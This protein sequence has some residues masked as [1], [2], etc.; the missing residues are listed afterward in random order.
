MPITGKHG[1]KR[2][3]AVTEA[4]LRQP[5]WLL[6]VAVAFC[7][8]GVLV[9]V[10]LSAGA[11]TS[12]GS[13]EAGTPVGVGR[14]MTANADAA[15]PGPTGSAAS[16]PI[17]LQPPPST[18]RAEESPR[19]VEPDIDQ[20]PF[21]ALSEEPTG[22][23]GLVLR[24]VVSSLCLDLAGD[25]AAEGA[26]VHQVPCTDSVS[27]RWQPINID[28]E[29]ATVNLANVGSG[30]CLEVV[31]KALFYRQVQQ[32]PCDENDSTQRWRVEEVDEGKVRL[33]VVRGDRCL[34]V[35]GSTTQANVEV[36]V[37][38]CDDDSDQHWGLG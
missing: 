38:R 10:L 20:Q 19:P 4:D 33:I 3:T 1:G 28:A 21:V 7:A 23:E 26:K 11:F 32:S 9:G 18:A 34:T 22:Q 14:L 29:S 8:A 15:T 30:L 13:G 37:A 31:T 6:P 27:Q 5:R 35:P 25:P 2:H 24:S 17:R 36:T 16:E 12:G